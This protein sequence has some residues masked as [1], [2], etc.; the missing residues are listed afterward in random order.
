MT[1]KPAN[2]GVRMLTAAAFM[3]AASSAYSQTAN[4]FAKFGGSWFGGGYIQLSNG[5][6]ERIRCRAGFTPAE[7]FILRLDIRCAGDSYNFELQSEMSHNSGSISG[8]WSENT[9]GIGGGLYGRINGDRIM[10]NVE[11]PAFNATFYLVTEGDKQTVRIQSPGSEISDVLIALNRSGTKPAPNVPA[12]TVPAATVP[13]A[14]VPA[15]TVPT[16]TVPTANVPTANAPVASAPAASA[17][18]ASAPDASVPTA[19][20]PTGSIQ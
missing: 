8:T 10:A 20:A 12:A 4:P 3:L 13:A 9:R 15:A 6:K 16:A 19:N 18:D 5:S 7:M 17:P 1:S 2:Y 11:S 14:T